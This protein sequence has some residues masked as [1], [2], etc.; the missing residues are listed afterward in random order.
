MNSLYQRLKEMSKDDFESLV[1][2]L[3]QAKYPSANITRVD[4]AGGD[5]GIDN[6]QGDLSD[7]P[8]VWQD[9]HF[10]NRVQKAQ[11]KQIVKSIKAAFKNRTPRHWV[12]CL[13]INLRTNEHNWFQSSI[14]SPYEKKYRGTTVELFQASHI[15]K[16]L[17][18]FKTVCEAF[19]PDAVSN[20]AK[21]KTLVTNSENLDLT[22]RASIT[23]EYARQYLVAIKNLDSRF[24]YEV[25][26][27]GER[28]P[29]PLREPGQLFTVRQGDLLTRVFARDV[30]AIR[31]D[32]IKLQIRLRKAAADKIR[33]AIETG[34]PQELSADEVVGI[35]SESP[36]IKFLNQ[37]LERSGIRVAPQVPNPTRLIPLR[38]VFGKGADAKEIQ[39]LPVRQAYFGHREVTLRSDTP[40]PIEVQLT[41]Q[42]SAD[43]KIDIRPIFEG[44]NVRDLQHVLQCI[45]ALK[46][47][48]FIEVFSVE[49]GVP[50]M[51]GQAPFPTGADVEEAVMDIINDAAIVSKRFG[52]AIKMPAKLND[53]DLQALVELKRIATGE[54][55][56][57]GTITTS[58]TK[59]E[60]LNGQVLA[61]LDGPPITIRVEPQSD[62]PTFHLFGSSIE[63]GRPIFECE[64]VAAQNIADVRERYIAAAPG[65]SISVVW[66]C[67]GV[68]RFISND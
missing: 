68:C 52:V 22:G 62:L 14:K 28:A 59:A 50:I 25:S 65:E 15:I 41:L 7:G 3:L 4:G 36:L 26:I 24:D 45:G 10:P 40:L 29:A 60:A 54:S 19:F 5:E 6:F 47:S 38:L 13:P 39:Y 2:Q 46:L 33:E 34:R 21:L 27:G 57:A 42:A 16:E 30:D 58:L 31:L 51:A 20:I 18:H 43:V 1:D 8:A 32:P 48:P 35:E 9:K 56:E 44:A 55:F 11:R 12:L 37:G 53:E 61:T 67:L 17:L 63:A 66:N 49:F 23:A 64:K